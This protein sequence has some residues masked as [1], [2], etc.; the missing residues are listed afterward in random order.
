MP[1]QYSFEVFLGKPK[2]GQRTQ[3]Y[4]RIRHPNG[5]VVAQSEGYN[6][7]ND[8]CDTITGIVKNIGTA[9]IVLMGELGKQKEDA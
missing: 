7:T 6:N 5:Q 8:A 1:Q 2:K 9:K 4:F 3:T